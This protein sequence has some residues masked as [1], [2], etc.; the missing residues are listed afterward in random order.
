V[1]E[2]DSVIRVETTEIK[3][4][5]ANVRL[6]EYGGIEG[7][8]Q[9]SQVS[10]RR[11]RSVQKFLKIGRR[12]MMEVLRVDDEKMYIDLSKKSLMPDSVE[13]ANKRWK[14]SKKVHEIM[15]EIAMKLKMPME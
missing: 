7:F 14:K 15:F 4:L 3:E 2:K 1:P 13:E 6:L 11:V 12:E 8:I 5:G 9:L 10:T